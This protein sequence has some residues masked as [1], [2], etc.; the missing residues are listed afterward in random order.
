MNL[1]GLARGGFG[2]L[3]VWLS[4]SCANQQSYP[5][6]EGYKYDFA[7]S[8]A[9]SRLSILGPGA[10]VSVKFRNTPEL[11]ETQLVRSDGMISLPLIGPISVDG[12]TPEEA[13]NLL[14]DAYKG[15]LIEPHIRVL[16]DKPAN[17]R[18][19]VGGQVL[20]T[21]SLE[22]PG[23]MT[24]LEAVMQAGG[25]DMRAASLANV[26]VIRHEGDTRRGYLVDLGKSISGY[27]TQPFHLRHNDIVY[28][29]RTT[30]VKLDQWIDQNINQIVPQFGA[31]YRKAL[32]NGTT[33]GFETPR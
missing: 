27:A 25:P 24:A 17:R 11:N 32:P 3:L 5:L 19:F 16:V 30:I 23:R 28:V 7:A 6:R 33:Y 1:L 8:S 13:R 10:T 14:L 26:V 2:L 12:Q 18:V 21:G 9:A 15:K 22:M 29:P 20:R 4:T 31:F